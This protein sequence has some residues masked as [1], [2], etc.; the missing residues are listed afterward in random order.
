MKKAVLYAVFLTCCFF[1]PV[2]A[3]AEAVKFGVPPWPGVTVKTEILAQIIEA[4]GHE[5]EQ[6]E[7][8][9][10]IVYNGLTTGDVDVYVASW[11]PLQNEMFKPLKEKNAVDIVGVNLDEAGVS[12]AV[13]TYVWEAGVR[14][15]ADLD[16][17]AAKFDSTIYSIEVGSG[18]QISTE[19]MI[20]NDVAGLG[21]WTMLCSPVPA[22]I[23]AVQDKVRENKW[24]VFHGWQPH[25]M[26]F[27]MDMK[28]LEGVPGSEELV[29]ES[30]VYTLA[31][32]DFKDRFP[33]VHKFL[34]NLYIKGATQSE[35]INE[36]GFKKVRPEE[37][38]RTWIPANLD[39]V[40]KWLEGVKAKDGSPAIEAVRKAYM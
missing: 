11:I 23:R 1:A 39:T 29:S 35:W 36:Y 20:N 5:T 31:S 3:H 40:E 22:M 6:L 32:L 4:M 25:W 19:K 14:T 33:Q 26:V 18:M 16:K 38:A 10:A 13:P 8:G 27:Q 34:G 28:F 2:N 7:V 30:T 24:V 21:D 12:L 17:H 37:I 9:P 15:I